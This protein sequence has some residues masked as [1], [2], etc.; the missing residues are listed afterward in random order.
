MSRG[1][2]SPSPQSL[3]RHRFSATLKESLDIARTRLLMAGA[4]FSFC[5]LVICWRLV[6]LTLF[7]H[8][9]EPRLADQTSREF[10]TGRAELLDRNGELLATTIRTSSVYANGKMV[11]DP[12]ESA[13]KL[14]EAFPKLKYSEL[15]GHFQS[16]KS[17]IW[18][19]RHI[20]PQQKAK[21]LKL[22]IPGLS[23]TRDYRRVYPYGSLSSHVLGFTDI[24]NRGI[25]GLEKGLDE[26]LRSSP[27]PVT[28]SLDVRFQDIV[29][30]E[31]LKGME[32]FSAV[33]ASG[34][35][36]D[37]K[38]GEI[39]SMVSLPDFDPNHPQNASED[40]LFNKNTLGIYEMGSIAKIINTAMVLETKTARLDTMIDTSEP[41]KVGR[42]RI[43]EIHNADYGRINVGEILVRSS[44]RG[45]A[46]LA[47]AAG[48]EKQKAFFEQIGLME[49]GKLELPESARPIIPRRWRDATV[50]TASYG[51]GFSVSPL[52]ILCGISSIAAGGE[53][54]RPTLLLNTAPALKKERVVSPKVSKVVRKLMRLVVTKGT[55]GKAKVPGYFV[56]GKTGTAKLLVKGRYDNKRTSTTFMGVFGESEKDLRYGILVRLE[57]PKGMKHT[58]GFNGAGWNAAPVS[59]RILSR[60]ATLTGMQ[61]E[62]TELVPPEPYF[63]TI[64][65]NLQKK[66]R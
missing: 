59:G 14:C 43:T 20:T 23:F 28:L 54:I 29:R 40:Q 24:D 52:Q 50:I 35:V 48:A 6:D 55:S 33:G 19:L 1:P 65:Y 18:V 13:Q 61:P 34:L 44:N 31:L 46:R 49:P 16:G 47:L 25:S 8:Q 7:Y 26:K 4:V 27:E 36:I 39:L 62:E 66:R 38:T 56:A 45:S 3:N 17:F 64:G 51:Y 42:F 5:I 10:M 11:I 9:H 21:I 53:K 32:E 37:L 41:L 15:L 12:V 63:Q 2:Y 30:H 57:D 58:F 22:G 60:I